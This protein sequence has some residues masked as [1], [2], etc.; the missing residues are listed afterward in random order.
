MAIAWFG[1]L[2][3]IGDFVHRRLDLD[4]VERLDGWLSGGLTQRIQTAPD[5]WLAAYD[6]APRW[7]FAWAAGVL[8]DKG[9][10]SGP[11]CGVLLP[12]RDRVGRRFPLI[13]LR[14]MASPMAPAVHEWLSGLESVLCLAVTEVWSIT[15]LEA[16]LSLLDDIAPLHADLA[17][18]TQDRL[19]P[20][21][22]CWAA[23]SA[24][25]GGAVSWRRHP[26]LPTGNAF[27]R[28]I[29]PLG[30]FTNDLGDANDRPL[31]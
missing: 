18:V 2:P 31:V 6:H 22:T 28:L 20:G 16:S 25:S 30:P 23:S 21:R 4:T 19:L 9:P 27:A 11:S 1:K 26:G 3:A 7:R 8:A 24:S 5:A 14:A 13:A 15:Q 10:W 17:S 29:A 12:S